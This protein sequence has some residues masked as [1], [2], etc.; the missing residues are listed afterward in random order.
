MAK[1]TI[2]KHIAIIMDG[3]GRWANAQK[4]P[5]QQ[6]HIAGMSAVKRVIEAC[7]KRGVPV[8]S[9]FAFSSENWNRPKEEVAGLMQLFITSIQ[10][11][12]EDL[13]KQNICLKFIGDFAP[14]AE[15]LQSKIHEVEAQTKKNQQLILNIFINYGGKWDIVQATKA[16]IK[17]VQAGNISIDEVNEDS[18]ALYLATAS[19]PLPDL[20]IRTSG[21]LRIS[22]FLLWQIAYTELYF[23]KVYWPEFTETHLDEA[24]KT[25]QKRQRRFGKVFEDNT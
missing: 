3:N 2:P 11:N 12:I 8:L 24:I 13:R 5:R 19:L 1:P 6:G 25:F 17:A 15:E 22:N 14:L 9:L 10:E 16:L 23:T 7:L 20:F 18:F 21:E 4:L